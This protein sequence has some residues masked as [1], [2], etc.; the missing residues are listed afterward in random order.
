M[1]TCVGW[2]LDPVWTAIGRPREVLGDLVE[3]D[4]KYNEVVTGW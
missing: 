1:E 2:H 4:G 3:S